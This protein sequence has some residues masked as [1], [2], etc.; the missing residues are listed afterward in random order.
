MKYM[1]KPCEIEAEIFSRNF[2]DDIVSFT[3]GK[4]TNLTIPKKLFGK[5]TCTIETLEGTMI[6]T[7]GDYIIRGLRG[8]YYPCKPDVFVK[9]YEPLEE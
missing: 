4:A 3:E 8:E 5:A 9:K 2:W 1:T 6:A 7:E